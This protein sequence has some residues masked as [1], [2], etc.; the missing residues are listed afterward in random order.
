MVRK[1][2]GAIIIIM[3]EWQMYVCNLGLQELSD[4]GKVVSA[5]LSLI[6]RDS[7]GFS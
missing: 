6:K 5:V 3:S 7:R 2:A 1:G 4:C